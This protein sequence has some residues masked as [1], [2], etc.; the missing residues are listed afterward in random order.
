MGSVVAAWWALAVAARGFS[1]P[2][3]CVVFVDQGSNPCTLHWQVYHWTARK[4]P[5]CII[6]NI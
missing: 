5:Q 2:A 6:L 1:C 3:G 4:V